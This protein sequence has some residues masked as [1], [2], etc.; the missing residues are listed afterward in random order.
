V[1]RAVS[2]DVSAGRERIAAI[3]SLAIVVF[4]GGYF[5]LVETEQLLGHYGVAFNVDKRWAFLLLIPIAQL[6]RGAWRGYRSATDPS[7]MIGNYLLG[8]GVL[9]LALLVFVVDGLSDSAVWRAVMVLGGLVVVG[10]LL[11]RAASAFRKR[12]GSTSP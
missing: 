3:V 2:L 8:A 12:A 11:Q 7:G 4:V 10:E 6:L 9:V 5:F 1:E